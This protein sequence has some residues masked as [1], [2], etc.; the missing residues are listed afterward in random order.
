MMLKFKGRE[1]MTRHKVSNLSEKQLLAIK[2]N[3]YRTKCGKFDYDVESVDSRLQSLQAKKSE[4][5]VEQVMQHESNTAALMA[6]FS[7]VKAMQAKT[8]KTVIVD[9]V[10][11]Q[12]FVTKAAVVKKALF[13]VDLSGEHGAMMFKAK[14][15]KAI[16]W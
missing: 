8:A 7:K 15:L 2:A 9:Q 11:R 6:N 12:A 3:Q 4:A 16:G 13:A 14:Q 1:V 5:M 10:S